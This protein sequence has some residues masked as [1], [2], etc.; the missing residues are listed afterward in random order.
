M[1]KSG[2]VINRVDKSIIIP[3]ANQLRNSNS[4][5][6]LLQNMNL[7]GLYVDVIEQNVSINGSQPIYKIDGVTKTKHDILSVNPKNIARI[8]YEDS[9][10]IRN[11]DKN[12]GG[13][14]NIILKK[15]EDG[16]SFRGSALGSP[17]TEFLNT[18]LYGSY[19]RA[20]SEFSVN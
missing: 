5:L 8:E 14:I 18:D 17:M 2:N 3:T 19:N 4:S 20:K 13:V 16:G 11:I 1:V 9:P 6:S 12:V 10:S 15:R 7:P